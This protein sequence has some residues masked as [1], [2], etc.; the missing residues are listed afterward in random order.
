MSLDA[1]LVGRTYGPFPYE[2]GLEKLR[3]FARAIRGG[4]PSPSVA[5]DA[6]LP[7]PYAEGSIAPPAFANVFAMVPFFR[8]CTDPSLGI[9][10]LMLVHG[11]QAYEFLAPVRAGDRLSTTGT[12][13]S[14]VEKP[15][16]KLLVMET[17]TTNGAGALV[18]RGR[19]TALVVT[20]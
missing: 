4:V 5:D 12:V 10:P 8:C 1:S 6:A 16:K 17:E 19:F 3:E 13:R 15:G 14:V 18:V 9:D 20:G 2:V 7:E 11:E